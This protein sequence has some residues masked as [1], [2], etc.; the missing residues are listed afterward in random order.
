MS[1]A[2]VL[3]TEGLD[4]GQQAGAPLA[5][6]FHYFMS[7]TREV[8]DRRQAEARRARQ[9]SSCNGRL[10]QQRLRCRV[11]EEQRRVLGRARVRDDPAS[12][13]RQEAIGETDG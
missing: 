12:P 7:L 2:Q 4:R 8:E 9:V 13:A 6:Q 5:R 11:C 1:A 10:A 3:N